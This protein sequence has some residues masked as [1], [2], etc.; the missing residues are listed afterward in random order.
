MFF[1]GMEKNLSKG[2]AK[3]IDEGKFKE[4]LYPVALQRAKEQLKTEFDFVIHLDLDLYLSEIFKINNLNQIELVEDAL[5]YGRSFDGESELYFQKDANSEDEKIISFLKE[6]LELL[7]LIHYYSY[8]NCLRI[9]NCIDKIKTLME[10]LQKSLKL[11]NAGQVEREFFHKDL[12]NAITIIK[13]LFDIKQNPS[14]KISQF[15]EIVLYFSNPQPDCFSNQL[16]LSI[17]GNFL[18]EEVLKRKLTALESLQEK[19]QETPLNVIIIKVPNSQ[20]YLFSDDLEGKLSNL[21]QPPEQELKTKAQSYINKLNSIYSGLKIWFSSSA[22]NVLSYLEQ[23]K[24]LQK[25]LEQAQLNEL[26]Q[27]SQA[28]LVQW[29][30]Q[31]ML[32]KTTMSIEAIY[33]EQIR[34]QNKLNEGLDLEEDCDPRKENE[35]TESDRKSSN[36]SLLLK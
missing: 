2:D 4:S 11:F 36:R 13:S 7:I 14:K 27:R 5:V 19:V 1:K 34:F 23:N 26:T 31:A 24:K 33:S 25:E 32:T 22:I 15:F 12:N 17:C 29:S 10:S 30:K 18:D 6:R 8:K 16:D 35:L 3:R 21:P 20:S 28:Q 9:L